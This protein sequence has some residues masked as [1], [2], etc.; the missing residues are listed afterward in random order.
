V[1]REEFLQSTPWVLH[2]LE[3]VRQFRKYGFAGF[4]VFYL[5]ESARRGYCNNRFEAEAR[6]AETGKLSLN[7]VVFLPPK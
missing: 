6:L 5:W 7:D 1:S 4:L 3:H 2:E